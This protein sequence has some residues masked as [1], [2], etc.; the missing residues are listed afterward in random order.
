MSARRP[1][2]GAI[3]TFRPARQSVRR[4]ADALVE[5]IAPFDNDPR[6]WHVWADASG[7]EIGSADLQGADAMLDRVYRAVEE[8]TA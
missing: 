4:V 6:H 8:P 7:A 5:E 3:R 2:L 1:A